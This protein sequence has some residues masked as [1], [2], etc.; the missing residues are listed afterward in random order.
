[1]PRAIEARGYAADGAFDVVVHAGEGEA[2][3][4]AEEIAV[5]VRVAG[6]RAE[7]SAARGASAALRTTRAALASLLYGGLRPTDAVRLG[8]AD[9][10]ARTLARA[11]AIF[12]MP[13]LLP[14]DP[15]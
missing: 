12:A 2:N 4:G 5:S 3:G 14:I 7:V 6:G 10:D 11:D 1:V 8:L 9:A 13:P 15:F